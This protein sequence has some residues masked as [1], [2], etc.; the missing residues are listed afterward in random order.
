MSA[1][2][3]R[4]LVKALMGFPWAASSAEGMI[5]PLERVGICFGVGIPSLWG[6]RSQVGREEMLPKG[7]CRKRCGSTGLRSVSP[8]DLGAPERGG[9][10]GSEN[11]GVEISA[12]K[13]CCLSL[14]SLLGL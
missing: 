11:H 1:A 6:W 3:I 2:L 10:L 9:K 5:C 13:R 12:L 4:T 14:L 7:S 8:Q